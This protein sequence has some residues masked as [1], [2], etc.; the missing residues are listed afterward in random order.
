MA[1]SKTRIC[2]KKYQNI[3][4]TISYLFEIFY[5]NGNHLSTKNLVLHN[6]TYFYKDVSGIYDI[7]FGST[8]KYIYHIDLDHTFMVTRE[9]SCY[10][11]QS[12]SVIC[13]ITSRNSASSCF[14]KTIIEEGIWYLLGELWQEDEAAPVP[15]GLWSRSAFVSLVLLPFTVPVFLY[16]IS[17]FCA[18]EV[19][20]LSKSCKYNNFIIRSLSI[21]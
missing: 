1:I 7:F 9:R 16:G 3:I 5:S 20:G 12:L 19:S 13:I 11:P 4:C 18:D 14:D 10:K 15:F 2:K 17:G 21:V 6:W 8:L